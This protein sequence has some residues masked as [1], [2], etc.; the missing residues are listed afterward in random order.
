MENSRET[1]LTEYAEFPNFIKD[2]YYFAMLRKSRDI[3][4]EI[5]ECGAF[6]VDRKLDEW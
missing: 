4:R 3:K 6:K 5:R 1:S 2:H